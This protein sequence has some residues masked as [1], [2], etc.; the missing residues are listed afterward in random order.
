MSERKS[1]WFFLLTGIFVFLFSSTVCAAWFVAAYVSD[2]DE[3]AYSIQQTVP[4]ISVS[5][6]SLN[7]GNVNVGRSSAP[8]SITIYNTG[9]SDLHISG[10]DL[11][12]EINYS[13]SVSEGAS[14]CGSATPTINP[15]S[16][17]IITVT[18]S[19]T[20][21]GRIE[22]NLILSSDDPDTPMINISLSGMGTIPKCECDFLPDTNVVPRGGTLRFAAMVSNN[23][24]GTW[25]FFFA[26]KVSKPNGGWYPP[27]G[28]L[29]GPIEVTLRMA[30]TKSKYL[31]LFIPNTAPLGTYTY[32]GYVGRPGYLW[33][34]CQFNFI[35][36]E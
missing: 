29:L 34:K 19:P 8:L 5:S 23:T 14:S 10:M 3:E 22:A 2:A 1:I 13:I 18:F 4:N 24:V 25:I 12:D 33:D 30:E 7:F 32:Y 17:C 35:V 6:S 31:S 28:Y 27:S 15:N 16:S 26:T 21:T 11:S 9:T 20:S 36:T